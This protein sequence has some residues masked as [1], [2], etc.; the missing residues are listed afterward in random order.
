MAGV[1]SSDRAA[2]I[3]D[4]GTLGS[5][6]ALMLLLGGNGAGKK[7][8]NRMAGM[9]LPARWFVMEMDARRVVVDR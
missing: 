1:I 2:S 5:P 4:A 3:P 6:R 9:W 7:A 8:W